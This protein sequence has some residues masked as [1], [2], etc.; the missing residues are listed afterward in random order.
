MISEDVKAQMREICSRYP[1]AR[2]GMLSCL[3]LAQA[4][5]G[6]ISRRRHGGGSRSHRDQSRRG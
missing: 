3:H 4:T 6:Y 1:T 2:S 5:E